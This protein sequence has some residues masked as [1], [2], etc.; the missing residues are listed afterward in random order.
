MY[1]KFVLSARNQ[2][3]Q[4][5][6]RQSYASPMHIDL[7]LEGNTAGLYFV[8]VMENNTRSVFKVVKH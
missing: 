6:F 2:L 3:G 5:I 7:T 1:D 4:E 8:E